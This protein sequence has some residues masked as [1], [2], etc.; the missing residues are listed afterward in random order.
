VRRKEDAGENSV[1][2]EDWEDLAE[3]TMPNGFYGAKN[4]WDRIEAPLLLIDRT[5][6]AFAIVHGLRL[7]RNYHNW[8]ERSLRWNKSAV[9]KLI[10]IFLVDQEK[11]TF[12]VWICA[13]EDRAE[14]RFWKQRRLRDG[15]VIEDIR[16]E[17]QDMLTEGKAI[18][19]SWNETDL[20]PVG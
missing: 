18:L 20:E 4:E 13:S 9:S 3:L 19:D 5:L 16:S 6:D 17:L 7:G 10:Q 2:A 1:H 11:L 14:K 8:P 12:T 15:V